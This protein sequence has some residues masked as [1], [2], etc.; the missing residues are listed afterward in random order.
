MLHTAIEESYKTQIL[1]YK[2][3]LIG[4]IKMS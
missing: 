4:T 1:T 2:L 3:D